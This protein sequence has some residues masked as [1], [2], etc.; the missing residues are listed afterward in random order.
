MHV[1]SKDLRYL[2]TIKIYKL[3]LHSQH[4]YDKILAM[5]IVRPYSICIPAYHRPLG[6]HYFRPSPVL[7]AVHTSNSSNHH[8]L[9]PNE[10]HTY[11]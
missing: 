7:T 10:K 8:M 5:A 1:I 3:P 9:A 11:I 6:S 4:L 2:S